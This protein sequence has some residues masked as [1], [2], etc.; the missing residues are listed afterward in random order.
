[1][2]GSSVGISSPVGALNGSDGWIGGVGGAPPDTIVAMG[3]KRRA[4]DTAHRLGAFDTMAKAYG[5]QRLTVLAY[6]RIA[7][8]AADGLVGFIGNVS[9]TPA[10]FDEQARWISQ[11][12][13]VVSL[14]DVAAA[15]VSG[16]VLPPRPLLITFDDGY[17]DNHE[18]AA[19]ILQAHGLAATAF[20]AT[21]LVGGRLVPW[22]DLAAWCFRVT[23][24]AEAELPILGRQRWNDGHRQAVSWIRAVKQLP[25]DALQR[26]LDGL[27]GALEVT[28]D[29]G[30]FA[31]LMLDW[32]GVSSMADQG[33]QFG[34]HTCTHPILTRIEFGHALREIYGSRD[35]V[36]EATGA[37]PLGF[38]YPN[39][40]LGDFDAAVRGAVEEAGFDLGFTLLPGPARNRELTADPL[41]IRRVYVHHGDGVSR[42]SAKVA[43]VARFVKAVR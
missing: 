15:A 8:P 7:D 9:A 42:L 3:W 41:A 19:P 5:R 1:V 28:V 29:D 32:Q 33:W 36:A 16:A 24:V 37:R 18:T 23:P 12:F 40:Q 43:G 13:S 6:H 27:P 35:R 11:R 34:A 10:E 17:R 20:L 26:S 22:W 30:A 31:R 39:G 14:S 4:I 38:A 2:N 21:D 25:N